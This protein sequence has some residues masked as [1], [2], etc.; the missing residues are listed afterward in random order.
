LLRKNCA[1]GEN[2]ILS[3]RFSQCVDDPGKAKRW[4]E[5]TDT[6]LWDVLRPHAP[7]EYERNPRADPSWE[8]AK[9]PEVRESVRPIVAEE[10]RVMTF[11]A[12][13]ELTLN[14]EAH[15]R[16]IDAVSGNLLLAFALLERRASGD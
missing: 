7:E 3:L 10:A 15:G 9:A 2:E 8:W 4:R 11:L 16:F 5:L 6:F 12:S 13:E 14:A 1:G